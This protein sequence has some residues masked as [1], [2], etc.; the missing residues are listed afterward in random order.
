[1]ASISIASRPG[2]AVAALARS[3]FVQ[4]G[5][6]QAA[7]GCDGRALSFPAAAYRSEAPDTDSPETSL[8]R[9][10]TT[11]NARRR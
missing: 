10:I 5:R 1:M 11:L 7:H 9:G 4:A 6:A 3:A 2:V 8:L